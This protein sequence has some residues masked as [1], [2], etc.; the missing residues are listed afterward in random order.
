MSQ[1]PTAARVY[2][3]AVVLVGTVMFGVCLP[4]LHFDQP[5]LFDWGAYHKGYCSDLTRT[6]MV[7]RVSNRIKQIYRIV[8]EAQLAAIWRGLGRA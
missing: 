2:V 5:L 7:G 1:L 4:L 8:L 6:L 3:A